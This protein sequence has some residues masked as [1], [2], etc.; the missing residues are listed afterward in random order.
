VLGPDD[1]E[2]LVDEVVRV[3]RC[4]GKLTVG[5]DP[6]FNDQGAVVEGFDEGPPRSLSRRMVP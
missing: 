5:T 2:G 1:R 3:R 4:N 6:S